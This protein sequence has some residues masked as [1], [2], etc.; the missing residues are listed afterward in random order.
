V[1]EHVCDE[2]PHRHFV[3]TIPKRLR[4]SFRFERY[5]LLGELCGVGPLGADVPAIIG[6]SRPATA[7]EITATIPAGAP[8]SLLRVTVGV[9]GR[10]SNPIQFTIA[11]RPKLSVRRVDQ[12]SVA[13]TWP[14]DAASFV[15]EQTDSLAQPVKSAARIIFLSRSSAARFSELNVAKYASI[16]FGFGVKQVVLK[17]SSC[18]FVP[19][20]RLRWSGFRKGSKKC[21]SC[22]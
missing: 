9:A 3:F 15:L 17:T 21:S 14:A 16:L 12:T 5:G 22:E 6:L 1:A 2:V 11:S 13:V 7:N 4:I 18:P 8:P 19:C 10:T 20:H